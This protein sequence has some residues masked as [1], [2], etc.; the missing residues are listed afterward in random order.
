MLMLS[1]Y[2]RYDAGKK[3]VQHVAG[4]TVADDVIAPVVFGD[5]LYIYARRMG[6]DPLYQLWRCVS[7]ECARDRYII[8]DCGAD[9]VWHCLNI[10]FYFIYLYVSCGCSV[11]EPG[12]SA[13]PIPGSYGPPSHMAVF[14]GLLH[15]AA[16]DEQGVS[17]LWRWVW[18][19]L[20][21]TLLRM[22]CD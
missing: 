14:Q 16:D 10:L 15:F 2:P 12:V 20:C 18:V 3:D 7:D 19:H 22:C 8:Y 21:V 1:C 5:S 6:G 9:C 13:T 4:L 17:R 11:V